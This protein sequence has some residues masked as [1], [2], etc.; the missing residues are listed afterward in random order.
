MGGDER[1]ASGWLPPFEARELDTGGRYRLSTLG[2]VLI[3]VGAAVLA[4]VVIGRVISLAEG[5]REGSPESL[6]KA[7][8]DARA[9][10]DA[11]AAC[12]MLAPRV[13]RDM[14]ALMRGV[15]APDASAADCPRYVLRSS[16]RS[17]FTDP[18]LPSFRERRLRVLRWPGAEGR[19]YAEVKAEGVAGALLETRLVDGEWKLDGLAAERVGFMAGCTD[20]GSTRAYCGCAFDRLA[21][22]GRASS[23]D[24]AE[25]SRAARTGDVPPALSQ[26][27]AACGR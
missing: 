13:Q 25:M 11:D 9:K 15:D 22:V 6:A 17:Q 2:R 19:R 20:K 18:A 21:D 12:D 7:F 3:L 4:L 5:P 8:V 16:E 14:V 27:A 26:A 23:Q 24:L 10:G 1:Q